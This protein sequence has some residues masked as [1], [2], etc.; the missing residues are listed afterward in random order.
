VVS[1]LLNA[2]RGRKAA[3]AAASDADAGMAR[4][5]DWQDGRLRVLLAVHAVMRVE[6]TALFRGLTVAERMVSL[7]L[8]M[9][10]VAAGRQRVSTAVSLC[11]RHP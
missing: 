11:L 8:E 5:W 4:G 9:V 6:L 3:A 1:H 2:G 10:R 7:C